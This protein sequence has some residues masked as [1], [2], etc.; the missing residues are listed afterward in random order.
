MDCFRRFECAEKL[1]MLKIGVAA[2]RK[3]WWRRGS[4]SRG[5]APIGNQ[6]VLKSD[7][8]DQLGHATLGHLLPL[9]VHDPL[10]NELASREHY[11]VVSDRTQAKFES[12]IPPVV[13][14][15]QHGLMEHREVRRHSDNHTVKGFEIEDHGRTEL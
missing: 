4:N 5:I 6:E 13:H 14:E 1:R 15:L 11:L 12:L 2:R 7:A 3:R 10:R 8:L 9:Y